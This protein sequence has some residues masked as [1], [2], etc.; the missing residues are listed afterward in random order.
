MSSPRG[1]RPG[2]AVNWAE[3][4]Q[5]G[6]TKQWVLARGSDVR[7]PVLLILAG[8]PGGTETGWFRRYNAAL[9]EHVTVV[10][11]EQRGAGKS[12]CLLFT[13]RRHMIPQQYVADGVAL[14]AYLRTRFDQN[15]LYLMG[16]SWGTFLGV[17]MVQQHPEWYAA[18]IGIGQMVCPATNDRMQYNWT[19]DRARKRGET[20]VV[21]K[22]EQNGPPPYPGSMVRVARKYAA[23]TLPNFLY[24][25]P[26]CLRQ[27][28][29][30]LAATSRR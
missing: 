25:W 15:T 16:H 5:L 23:S 28:V 1:T 29:I 27:A 14:T 22:L 3:K 12:F 24:M 26:T 20:K 8:G 19:L 6:E 17:W 10:H 4:I 9:E 21:R 2:K 7:N 11:W 13:D 30:L 18:H